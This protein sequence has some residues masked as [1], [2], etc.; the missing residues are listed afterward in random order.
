MTPETLSEDILF[1]GISGLAYS[2]KVRWKRG[3]RTR[4]K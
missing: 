3:K 1:I 2:A 4:E